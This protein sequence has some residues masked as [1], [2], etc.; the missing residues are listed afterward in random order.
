MPTVQLPGSKTLEKKILMHSC[1]QKKD[2]ILAKELQKHLFK[3]DRKHGV[4]D[5]WKN[6]KRASKITWTDR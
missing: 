6:R 5:Q 3:D 2:V 1:I 4:I